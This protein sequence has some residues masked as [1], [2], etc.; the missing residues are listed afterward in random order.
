MVTVTEAVNI[1]KA[2]TKS[3]LIIMG[4]AAKEFLDNEKNP[5]ELTKEQI[6]LFKEAKRMFKEHPF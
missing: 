2:M 6:E 3:R 4:K 5:K 1:Y